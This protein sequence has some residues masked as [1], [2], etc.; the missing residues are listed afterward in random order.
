[1]AVLRFRGL[2]APMAMRR[3][4]GVLDKGADRLGWEEAGTG[5]GLVIVTFLLALLATTSQP[6]TG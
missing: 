3:G 5:S 1:M 4:S 2:A 6:T